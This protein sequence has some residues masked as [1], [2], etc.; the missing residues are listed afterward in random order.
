MYVKARLPV[1]WSYSLLKSYLIVIE[2][3][4][5]YVIKA[6]GLGRSFWFIAG[7]L[8]APMQTNSWQ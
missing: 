1:V 6:S 5:G 2:R 3:E 4:G 7:Y 8:Q